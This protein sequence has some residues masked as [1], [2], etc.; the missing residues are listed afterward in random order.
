MPIII[1]RGGVVRGTRTADWTHAP[2]PAA[3]GTRAI[4]WTTARAVQG[5]RLAT[6]TSAR[7]VARGERIV[8]WAGPVTARGSRT[9]AWGVPVT[10]TIEYRPGRRPRSTRLTSTL[11]LVISAQYEHTGTR[12]TLTVTLAGQFG[13]VP[14]LDLQ[15]Q[16]YEGAT[17]TSSL[18]VVL[19]GDL[20]QTEQRR[21]ATGYVTVLRGYNRAASRLGSVRLSELIPWRLSP[22]PLPDRR[23]PCGQR[24]KPQT[25]DVRG[26]VSSA[27]QAA[28]MT[29]NF[30]LSDPLAGQAWKEGVR[31][32]STSG[33]TPDQVW[34]DTYG[35]LGYT[36]T[37][38]GRLALALPAGG[39][40]PYQSTGVRE[41]D[42]ATDLTVR[43]EA[44]NTPSHLTVTAADLL[45]DRPN[46]ID[47]LAEAPDA[48]SLQ[49]ELYPDIEWYVTTPTTSGETIKGFRKSAG[50]ITYTN[51]LTRSDVEVTET[52]DGIQRTRTFGRVVTGYTSTASTYDPTCPDALLQQTTVKRSYGYGINTETHGAIFSGP[53]WAGG[54]EVGDTLAD[55]SQT[56]TQTFS[57][58]GYLSYRTTVT[59]KLVSLQQQGADGP[60]ADRGPLT[61]REYVTTTLSEAYSAIG[62]GKFLRL[63]SLSGAQQLPLYDTESGDAV[64]LASRGGTQANGE[65]TLDQVP[66]QVRCPDPCD[67]PKVAY[68]Q[69]VKRVLSD[70]REGQE[71]TRSL[72]FVESA[73][74]LGGY[75]D[76][77]VQSLAPTTATDATLSTVRDWRPGTRLDGVITGVVEGYSLEAAAGRASARVQ[78]RE[79]VLTSS[80]ADPDVDGEGPWRDMVVWRR[81][82]GVV[83]NHLTGI[84]DGIPQFRRIFVRATGANTPSPGDEVEW[85]NDTRFGPTS[86]G[87]YGN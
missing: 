26:I 63:W 20:T 36:Y 59:R 8:G 67:V 15:V 77:I 6:W 38:H 82:G 14:T 4:S 57:P 87:N 72:P 62:G 61:A 33:K 30:P 37:V 52:V 51:E 42:L 11:G 78:V 32:Y 7:T 19:D 81:P 34:G 3:R 60:L 68:P 86:T 83:V 80:T 31:E 66:A 9:V 12:E 22:T 29:L 54:Y 41:D 39:S 58:E 56:V 64:R 27:F 69:T 85:R 65:E 70:G 49:R 16:E 55:E 46:I 48:A 50:V 23:V 18:Q 24:P 79:Y 73:S 74:L 44:G 10:A 28:G 76:V 17:Q 71:V 75:A 40:L 47:L 25:A 2:V 53:G 43:R 84:K 35:Q 1:S 21:T 45:M 5:A 13:P